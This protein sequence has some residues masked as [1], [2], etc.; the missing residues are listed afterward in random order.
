MDNQATFAG[1]FGY[2]PRVIAPN[3]VTLQDTT[4]TDRSLYSLRE[5]SSCMCLCICAGRTMP[6]TN[7]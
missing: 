1:V 5:F 2:T 6:D 3:P 4:T 7:Q